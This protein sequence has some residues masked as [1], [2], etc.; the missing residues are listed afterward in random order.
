M[1]LNSS[2]RFTCGGLAAAMY[3]CVCVIS[4]D[5]LAVPF[6]PVN[7][8]AVSAD[9]H[10]CSYCECYLLSWH[11]IIFCGCFGMF[12]AWLTAILGLEEILMCIIVVMSF[13]SANSLCTHVFHC[14][15][16]FTGNLTLSLLY[17]LHV[18]QSFNA[19][20]CHFALYLSFFSA[21]IFFHLFLFLIFGLISA[22]F[23]TCSI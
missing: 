7:Y 21:D 1:R 10:V 9:L 14:H 11:S 5:V 17:A 2:S 23:I 22:V 20:I 8:D 12:A 18:F 4:P 15:F 13:L 3:A 16:D 19:M 6:L